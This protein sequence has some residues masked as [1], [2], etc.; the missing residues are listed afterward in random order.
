[1]NIDAKTLNMIL[2]RDA[3]IFQYLQIN[4]YDTPHEQME[5]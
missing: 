3:R 4:Q 1:M 2:P 5:K